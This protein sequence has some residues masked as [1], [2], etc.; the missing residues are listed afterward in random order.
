MGEAT[1]FESSTSL[2]TE[3]YTCFGITLANTRAL[4]LKV[5]FSNGNQILIQYSRI[6]SPITFN[7]K[8]ELALN[9]ST[10]RLEIQGSNLSPLLDYLGEQR[11]AW[12]KSSSM[13][14]FSDTIMMRLGEPEIQA[15]QLKAM[16]KD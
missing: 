3:N 10:L 1:P 2:E 6:L 16:S 4:V 14:S 5:I 12:I 11:L 7:G 8:N 15:I 13:D 9:T